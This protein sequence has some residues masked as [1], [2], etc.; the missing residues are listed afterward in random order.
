M[1][2]IDEQIKLH[3]ELIKSLYAKLL[4]D[5]RKMKLKNIEKKY[6]K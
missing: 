6:R 5:V 4:K 2:E 1:S 3:K